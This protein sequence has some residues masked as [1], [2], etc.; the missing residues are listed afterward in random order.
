MQNMPTEAPKAPLREWVIMRAKQI[1]LPIK[2][3]LIFFKNIL[4]RRIPKK[5]S[6]MAGLKKLAKPFGLFSKP[7]K[8]LTPYQSSTRFLFRNKEILAGKK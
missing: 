2:K 1:T 5:V 4:F 3:W 6:G 8:T 7:R